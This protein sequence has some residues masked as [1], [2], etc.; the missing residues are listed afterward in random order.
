MKRPCPSDVD[1]P[2]PPSKRTNGE[3][4][5]IN[6]AIAHAKRIA[7]G[8]HSEM[9]D[10]TLAKLLSVPEQEDEFEFVTSLMESFINNG[11]IKRVLQYYSSIWPKNRRIALMET[12]WSRGFFEAKS[13]TGLKFLSCSTH[14]KI[15]EPS[16][17]YVLFLKN[18]EHS[19]GE[20]FTSILPQRR[21]QMLDF[22]ARYLEMSQSDRET[23]LKSY[24]FF[25]Q[26][27]PLEHY[28]LEDESILTMMVF[29]SRVTGDTPPPA[30][31]RH[32]QKAFVDRL[33]ERGEYG[34]VGVDSAVQMALAHAG[35]DFRGLC[36]MVVALAPWPAVAKEVKRRSGVW[37]DIPLPQEPK[38]SLISPHVCLPSLHVNQTIDNV[39]FIRNSATLE[40]AKAE[41]GAPFLYVSALANKDPRNFSGKLCLAAFRSP[42]SRVFAVLEQETEDDLVRQLWRHVGQ[43][44][45]LTHRLKVVRSILRQ[46]EAFNPKKLH[47][48]TPLTLAHMKSTSLRATTNWLWNHD[49][50]HL[51]RE[52]WMKWPLTK[53]QEYHLAYLMEVSTRVAEKIGFPKVNVPVN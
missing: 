25:T 32:T 29:I 15:H 7:N 14:F 16:A 40:I 27:V 42:T 4:A 53:S 17:H 30:Y 43:F 36:D 48:M 50:C 41:L 22:L 33:L 34:H 35:N 26:E 52:E 44:P 3:S 45:M 23:H 28:I 38:Q 13:R 11:L 12:L 9:D 5:R 8:L 49:Y 51:S 2:P 24:S 19:P 39:I 47:D 6:A 21:R 18:S 20:Y 46:H 1:H 10:S 37:I 31:F